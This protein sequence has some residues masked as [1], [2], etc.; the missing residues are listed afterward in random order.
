[1]F[2]YKELK[3]ARIDVLNLL[4]R[5]DISRFFVDA[6]FNMKQSFGF[7]RPVPPKAAPSA[8]LLC[9][10][11][12]ELEPI[13]RHEDNRFCSE[14][15][16]KG[17]RWASVNLGILMCIDCS[18]IHRNLGV[19]ITVV[20]STTLDKWLPK[21]VDV[22]KAIGNKKAA[23]Y[24]E[25]QLPS[26]FIRPSHQD[27]VGPVEN[28]IR[29]K[30]IRKEWVAKGLASPNELLAQG[31]DISGVY[32]AGAVGGVGG[33]GGMGGAGGAGDAIDGFADFGFAP[34]SS[35]PAGFDLLDMSPKKVTTAGTQPVSTQPVSTQ[36]AGSQSAG[37][38]AGNGLED[39]FAPQLNDVFSK[40]AHLITPTTAPP[41]V[42]DWFPDFSASQQPST[43]PVVKPALSDPFADL[44]TLGRN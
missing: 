16:A 41:S 18:G 3:R 31:R 14:C 8:G 30:Y 33:T 34:T 28:F 19:H 10:A 35:V 38:R 42:D 25:N 20:K 5:V 39:F 2:S 37:I 26:G 11:N 7:A 6:I 17:P 40:P 24:W 32:G 15:G 27:G 4:S 9:P 12:P 23:S 29:G 1:M 36:P 22:C 44:T 43:I 13:L 21:W